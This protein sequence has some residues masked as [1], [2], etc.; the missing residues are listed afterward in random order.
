MCQ[1]WCCGDI[2]WGVPLV[3][4][5][6]GL[7]WGEVLELVERFLYIS[8]H[9]DVQYASLVVPVQCD[10]TVENP[11]PILCDFIFSWSACMRFS[12]SP[13]IWYLIPKSFTT[14]VK[15]VPFFF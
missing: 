12:E 5:V 14:M 7:D 2:V 15:V 8:C 9:G 10:S 11:C 3:G 1:L 4:G 13:F 6:L